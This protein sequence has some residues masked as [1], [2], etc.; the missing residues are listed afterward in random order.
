MANKFGKKVYIIAEIGVNHEGNLSLAKSLIDL[1]KKGGADA[2][3]FQSYKAHKI[4]AK[5]SPAYWDTDKEPTK[6]QFE[7]FRKFDGFGESEYIELAKYCEYVGID[8]MSTPFDL[9]AVDFLNPLQ[10][11]FKIASADIT[12]Y[13]LLRRVAKCNKPVILSTGCSE[14]QEIREAVQELKKNGAKEIVLLHCILNYPTANS[15]ANLNMISSLQREFPE[16]HIGYSD[17]TVPSAAME[18]LST[19]YI[20]GAR[21][22]EK[23]FT[24]DK[25]LKG[26]DHYHSMDYQDLRSFVSRVSEIDEI[27]GV[28]EKRPLDSELQS[29]KYARRSLHY[30]IALEKGHVLTEN[31]L[32]CLRPGTGVSPSFIDSILGKRLNCQVE[33]GVRLKLDDFE[34]ND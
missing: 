26:N 4:A 19:A 1:A 25:T 22:I 33:E 27:V 5:D 8:F 14:I 34:I 18:V 20:L 3:K 10:K 21:V 12:N 6:S 24:H 31:D 17:H 28:Q 11:S 32:I 29:I 23:H 7:L 2:A 9:E 13:P 15:N 30:R 16:I